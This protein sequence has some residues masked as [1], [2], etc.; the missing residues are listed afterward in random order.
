[1][2]LFTQKEQ[3]KSIIES[4]LFIAEKPVSI[5]I[6]KTILNISENHIKEV[7]KELINEYKSRNSGIIIINIEDSY[8]M[9]TNPENADWIKIFKNLNANNKLSEQAFETLAIIAYKQP[10]TKAEVEKIRNVNSD[11]AIK[12]LIEKKLIKIVGKKDVPGR[13]FLYGTTKEFLKLF[14]LSSLSELP[15][16]YELQKINA[17]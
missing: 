6:L 10:I 13:P 16:F 2:N 14:G 12:S 7:I 9:V 15:G 5:K 1:M 4:I 3:L 8:Q 17:A 11:Y